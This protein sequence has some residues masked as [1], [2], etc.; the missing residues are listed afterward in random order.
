MCSAVG[1]TDW[2]HGCACAW[3]GEQSIGP[4]TYQQKN[5]ETKELNPVKAVLAVMKK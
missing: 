5:Y 4:Y 2:G 1:D 3:C